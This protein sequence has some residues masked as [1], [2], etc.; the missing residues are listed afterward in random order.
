MAHHANA[1]PTV[2][3]LTAMRKF[4]HQKKMR[5]SIWA[6]APLDVQ[7]ARKIDIASKMKFQ[8]K[9]LKHRFKNWKRNITQ[10]KEN[11]V[12]SEAIGLLFTFLQVFSREFPDRK[13]VV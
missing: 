7:K 10:N 8:L 5:Q 3:T 12:Q 13:S 11:E 1:I 4:L 6:A 2:P 9:L